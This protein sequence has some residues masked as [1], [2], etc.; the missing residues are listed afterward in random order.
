MG[1]AKR[2]RETNC[3][4]SLNSDDSLMN[5]IDPFYCYRSWLETTIL[6]L[7]RTAVVGHCCRFS[8]WNNSFLKPLIIGEHPSQ[9]KGYELFNMHR[10]L[11][12]KDARRMSRV[13]SVATEVHKMHT[14]MRRMSSIGQMNPSQSD[15][16]LFERGMWRL[17][18]LL[19]FSIILFDNFYL[20]YIVFIICLNSKQQIFS[21]IV[22][23]TISPFL[24]VMLDPPPND[25]SARTESIESAIRWACLKGPI[26]LGFRGCGMP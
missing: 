6:I 26:D 25:R 10:Q 22:L 20:G 11:S 3:N 15:T 21:F 13:P 19:I 2:S 16:N 1:I 14:Q 5:N 24:L 17:S 7:F 23:C 9:M 18:T 4:E 12:E 8:K